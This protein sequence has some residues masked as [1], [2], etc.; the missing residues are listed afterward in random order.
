MKTYI[1]QGVLVDEE[2]LTTKFACDY[3][4]CCGACCWAKLKCQ[5]IGCD[6]TASEAKQIRR[7]KSILAEKV[8][9]PSTRRIA[10]TKNVYT[11]FGETRVAITKDEKCIYSDSKGCIIKQVYG[12]APASCVAYPLELSTHKIELLHH[13]DSYCSPAYYKGEEENIW[14]I[15]FLKDALVKK[16]GEEFFVM[17]KNTQHDITTNKQ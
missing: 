3:N 2:V 12:S 11:A 13:S 4:V 6:L 7:D 5:T 10:F 14:I 17:L 9:D 1:V 8:T 15:D 16:Y